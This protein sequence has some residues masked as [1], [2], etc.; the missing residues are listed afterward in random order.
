MGRPREKGQLSALDTPELDLLRLQGP[1]VPGQHCLGPLLGQEAEH[2]EGVGRGLEAGGG[3]EE[4]LARTGPAERLPG[5][6]L[7]VC[8]G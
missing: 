3:A 2:D 4:R 8:L 5:H 7:Q 6:P 1:P